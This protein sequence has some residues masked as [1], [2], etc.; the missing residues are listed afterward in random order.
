M[1]ASSDSKSTST[2]S[3]ASLARASRVGNHDRDRLAHMHSVR[4][5]ASGAKGGRTIGA[6]SRVLRTSWAWI[7][8]RP[9]AA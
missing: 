7:V 2:A 9:D 3:A 4:S 6:P 8:P 5:I 1:L